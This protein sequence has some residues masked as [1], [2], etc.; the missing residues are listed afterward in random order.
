MYAKKGSHDHGLRHPTWERIS[1]I[2]L[3]KSP[4]NASSKV[5]CE[6]PQTGG[7]HLCMYLR[8]NFLK[9]ASSLKKKKQSVL[10]EINPEYSLERL[11]DAQAEASV[12]WPPAVNSQP[13]GKDPDAEKDWGQEEKGITEDEVVVWHHQLNGHEFEQTL[14]DSERT[15]KP[16][17]L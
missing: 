4:P 7:F 13:I 5:L 14:G 3:Y 8:I 15:G 11:I 17:M 2:T 1:V 16:D 10:K 6:S 9:P 12:L